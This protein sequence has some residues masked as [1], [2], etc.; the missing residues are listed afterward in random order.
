MS[1]EK[2]FKHIQ[3]SRLK[4]LVHIDVP[5]Q[6]D[7]IIY[8]TNATNFRLAILNSFGKRD[9]N[10]DEKISTDEDT[11]L[12]YRGYIK[13]L[14]TDL[15][16]VFPIGETRSKNKYKKGVGYIAK[17][18]LFRGDVSSI[19]CEPRQK[20]TL[21]ITLIGLTHTQAFS[22]AIRE[23]FSD[24]LRLS[25]HPSNNETKISISLLPTDTGLTTP[26]HST[27]AIRLDGTITTG[28]RA[29]FEENDAYELIYEN[30]RPSY[31]REKSPLLSWG[32]DKG[33]ILCEPLY[34]SGLIIRPALG[35]NKLAIEDVDAAK[36]RALSEVNSPVVLRG[37]SKTT[38]RD[39]FVEKTKEFG[40]PTAWKFGLV[41]EVKDQ[42]TDSQG[43]N[44]VLSAEWMPFHYD[45]LFKTEKRT[46][47]NGEEELI[48]TPPR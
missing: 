30:S 23:S 32:E 25:I 6:L 48:S 33:G 7:E 29:S 19:D 3:F 27:I 34:P 1:I 38:N 40:E 41:L 47:P 13:F 21:N 10:V 39:L 42:G 45:G 14:E 36:V 35:P 44:N 4:D 15:M 8:T 5:D 43:L 26:W 16:T 37:F 17:Q 22:R 2:G 24:H 11:C 18:M 12:T 20:S 31:F 46:K 28:H 9:F